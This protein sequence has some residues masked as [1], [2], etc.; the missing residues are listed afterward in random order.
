MDMLLL[1]IDVRC[2]TITI[3]SNKGRYHAHCSLV[4]CHAV[5]SACPHECLS[6][7]HLYFPSYSTTC[8]SDSYLYYHGHSTK[9]VSTCQLYFP[10]YS[11]TCMSD[12]YLYYHGHSTKCVS[13]CQLYFTGYTKKRLPSCHATLPVS[14]C[15]KGLGNGDS[16]GFNATARF[17][18]LQ[19]PFQWCKN[20][21]KPTRG[22]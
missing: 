16:R 5:Q 7:C 4:L 3:N 21:Q 22:C 11:T 19:M 6:A 13:T 10:T 1:R 8:M 9:C 15:D 18:S 17:G 20:H 2:V 12:S 14:L